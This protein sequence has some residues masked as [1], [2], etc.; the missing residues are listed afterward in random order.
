MLVLSRKT[1]QQIQI[2]ENI[3]ITVLEVKGRYVR[4]GVDAP[5]DVKIV[6]GELLRTPTEPQE[7]PT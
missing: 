4:L 6:R 5:R 3:T 1:P 2:G 7:H